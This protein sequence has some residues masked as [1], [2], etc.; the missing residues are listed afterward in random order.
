MTIYDD[1]AF[2]NRMQGA[3]IN[4]LDYV[5]IVPNVWYYKVLNDSGK[6]DHVGITI[7]SELVKLHQNSKYRILEFQITYAEFSA[8]FN[9][10]KRQLYSAMTRLEEGKLIKRSHR[11]LEIAGHNVGNFLYITLNVE[12]IFALNNNASDLKPTLNDLKTNF[13]NLNKQ[14]FL[15]NTQTARSANGLS[16]NNDCYPK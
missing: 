12:Q 3:K 9:Y 4:N 8:K 14:V 11:P 1:S 5:N 15:T 13:S 10:S 7:L 2:C 6:P 16:H